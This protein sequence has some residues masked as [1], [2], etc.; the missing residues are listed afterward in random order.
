MSEEFSLAH[1]NF[2]ID[3]LRVEKVFDACSTRDCETFNF[4]PAVADTRAG[5]SGTVE[6]ANISSIISC[7]GLDGATV[8]GT[9]TSRPG[10]PIADVRA[11]VVGFVLITVRTRTG[12]VVEL[13]RRVTFT[14]RVLL[15]APRPRSMSVCG[16]ALIRC[17]G[18]V[19]VPEVARIRCSVG[20]FIIIKTC[21]IVEVRIPVLGLCPIPPE[22]VVLA[23]ANACEVFLN[24]DITA[25]PSAQDFFPP[26]Q[27]T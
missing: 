3:C 2:E 23:E 5:E 18:C 12:A 20:A 13:V 6:F 21:G 25:F 17:L 14:T 11:E 26:Q 22:C 16:E 10:T 19:L 27:N 8:E 4:N 24:R 9:I 7:V 15:F 1:S